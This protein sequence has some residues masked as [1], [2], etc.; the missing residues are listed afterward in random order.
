MNFPKSVARGLGTVQDFMLET[1]VWVAQN[2]PEVADREGIVIFLRENLPYNSKETRS[3]YAGWIALWSYGDGAYSLPQ[4]AWQAYRDEFLL[5]RIL[6]ATWL[7]RI[8]PLQRL[9]TDELARMEPG[10]VLTW[11]QVQAFI[12]RHAVGGGRRENQKRIP[13]WLER[14]GFVERKAVKRGPRA[15]SKVMY[16]VAPHFD[17]TAFLILLHSELAPTPRTVGM[18]EILD[19]PFWRCLGG[20][21]PSQVREA[22]AAAQAA[23]AID[24]YTHVDQL[25]QV[26]TRYSLAELLERRL[27]L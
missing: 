6:G 8:L 16:V 14:L 15:T 22:L 26:T 20:R 27:R 23:G 5:R 2:A 10:D 12:D 21:E 17:A 9:I 19:H 11:E 24:R 4:I 18:G 25:E 1:G 7:R 13:L 3:R